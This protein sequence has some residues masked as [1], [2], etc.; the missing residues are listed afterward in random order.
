[1]FAKPKKRIL[2]VIYTKILQSGDRK[3]TRA[4]EN[5]SEKDR[6]RAR[7]AAE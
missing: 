6:R 3:L 5:G 2:C 1:M 4:N 7:Q